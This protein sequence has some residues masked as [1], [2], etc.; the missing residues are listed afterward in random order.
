MTALR[1]EPMTTRFFSAGAG[2]VAVLF[3]ATI[4][5]AQESTSALRDWPVY[6]GNAEG[7]RY[8][9]LTQINRSNVSQLQIAWQFDPGEGTPN[10]RFQAQPIVIDGVMYTVTPGS[11]VVALNGATG[12]PK[13]LIGPTGK[14][15]AS[16]PDS[17][18]TCTRSTP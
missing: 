4:L 12:K 13:S 2:T 1:S 11:S 3:L 8:S 5:K 16:S 6:G 10:G 17:A 15:S 18:A 9:T 7:M 14:S